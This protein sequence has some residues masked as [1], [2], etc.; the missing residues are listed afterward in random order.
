MLNGRD[1]PSPHCCPG[2]SLLNSPSSSFLLDVDAAHEHTL[3]TQHFALSSLSHIHSQHNPTH[4]SNPSNPSTTSSSR[5]H[6]DE[7]D[8]CVLAQHRSP[9]HS[10]HH[11]PS[12]SL[13]HP[14][15]SKRDVMN[16]ETLTEGCISSTNTMNTMPLSPPRTE[17]KSSTSGIAPVGTRSPYSL[18][19]VARETRARDSHAQTHK[20]HVQSRRAEVE[21]DEGVLDM[22]LDDTSFM[23]D[24]CA[25]LCD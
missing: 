1:K 24:L 23:F 2:V 9:D 17:D 15:V 12:C 11:S 18:Q 5:A 14:G 7:D 22:S 16:R 25:Q 20:L 10:D 4:P 21:S 13:I 8:S 3:A 6:G 19:D